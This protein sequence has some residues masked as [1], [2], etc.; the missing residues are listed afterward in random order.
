MRIALIFLAVFFVTVA[1]EIHERTSDEDDDA[2]ERYKRIHKKSYKDESEHNERRNQYKRCRQLVKKHN[3]QYKMGLVRFNQ[4]L[5]RFKEKSQLSFFSFMIKENFLC[6]M[7]KHERERL[8]TGNRDPKYDFIKYQVR[9]KSINVV[10][11]TQFPAGPPSINWNEKCPH[12]I[13]R[14]KD[15]GFYC[16]S[17][18]AFSAISALEFHSCIKTNQSIT[19]SEQQLI[20]CNRNNQTGIVKIIVIRVINNTMNF[21]GNWGC[22]GGSQCKKKKLRKK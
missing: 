19:L 7:F 20:D 17:C 12:C 1:K 21:Q 4:L 8:S 22:L 3:E 9:G 11:T 16:N 5:Y 14:I 2:F 6:D 15:Q 18:W 13:T 10:N